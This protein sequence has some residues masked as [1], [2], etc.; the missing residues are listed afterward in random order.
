MA[1]QK[2]IIYF[3]INLYQKL[4]LYNQLV[5]KRSLEIIEFLLLLDYKMT[6]SCF[7]SAYLKIKPKC[8]SFIPY[9]SQYTK[10]VPKYKGIGSPKLTHNPFLNS[11][12]PSPCSHSPFIAWNL[13]YSSAQF[14]IPP[15]ETLDSWM[16]REA[17]ERTASFYHKNWKEK[18]RVMLYSFKSCTILF[19]QPKKTMCQEKEAVRFLKTKHNVFSNISERLIC[20]NVFINYS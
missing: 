20:R 14:P 3:L 11:D 2:K 9:I 18:L 19:W 1:R 12:L 7:F 5:W 16:E 8:T 4:K 6:T 15:G 17:W 13:F 10:S